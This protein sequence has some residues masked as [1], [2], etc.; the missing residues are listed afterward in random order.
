MVIQKAIFQISFLIITKITKVQ[1]PAKISGMGNLSP[2]GYKT[3]IL[4][5][6]LG[7]KTFILIKLSGYKTFILIKLSSYKTFILSCS[8][9][10]QAYHWTSMQ[11][12]Y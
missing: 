8:K 5:K 3:F 2:A 1:K 10:V 11:Q 6:L 12:V 7:Y 4:I 9:N